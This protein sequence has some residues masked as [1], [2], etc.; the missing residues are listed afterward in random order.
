MEHAVRYVGLAGRKWG[1]KPG[2]TTGPTVGLSQ[3]IILA[4]VL[5]VMMPAVSRGGEP[6]PKGPLQ[7]VGET[8]LQTM[9]L[10][11]VPERHDILST[12]RYELS[13]TN[14]WTN[15]W[16]NTPSFLLD[17]EVIQDNLGFDIGVGHRM[18]LGLSIP[19]I[20]RTGG[21]L[22][23]IIADFHSLLH[24]DQE[25]RTDY[26][27]NSMTVRYYN[28]R[29]GEW[30]VLLN[31][32]DQGTALG[33][34]S[35]TIRTQIYRGSGWLRSV[36]FTGLFRFPTAS[37]RTYYGTGG[38]DFAF[39][40]ATMHYMKPFYLYTTLGYGRYGSGNA[41]GIE[42]RPYQLTFFGAVEWPVSRSLSLVIQEL[43]NS[44]VAMD[45]YDFSSP[46]HE[47]L[48]GA[49]QRLSNHLTLQYGVIE[50][51][52]V[53]ENSVDFGLSFGVSYRP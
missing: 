30:S 20:T 27:Y 28:A 40:L 21:G 53:F 42:L 1:L 35:L 36:L 13:L 23:R 25:G 22:D 19:I 3:L 41:L 26:P 4:V 17:L 45:Y 12:G 14:A 38:T 43:S 16:N 24:I 47:L 5:F 39:S 18:E 11:S 49:K 29:T 34:A 52:F 9:R 8:P 50:N 44:G 31:K 48:I 51:L 46:T 6:I 2:R 32:N 37:D 10:N 33:D 15:R 7:I